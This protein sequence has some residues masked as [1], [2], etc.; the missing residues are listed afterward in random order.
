MKVLTF[1]DKPKYPVVFLTP[2]T[3]LADLQKEYLTPFKIRPEDCKNIHLL[4]NYKKKTSVT[5]MREWVET[6]LLGIIKCSLDRIA[7]KVT[8]AISNHQSMVL[9][10]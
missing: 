5:T 3:L 2:A 10:R 1:S 4:L 8:L 6:L 9:G 7:L